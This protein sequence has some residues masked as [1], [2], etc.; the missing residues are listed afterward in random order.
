MKNLLSLHVIKSNKTCDV[1]VMKVFT[2]NWNYLENIQGY[3]AKML[4]VVP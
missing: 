1:Y 4:F 3:I 2:A